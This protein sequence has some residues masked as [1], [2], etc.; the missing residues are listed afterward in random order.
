MKAK[1]NPRDSEKIDSVIRVTTGIIGSD[2]GQALSVDVRDMIS[3][4]DRDLDR[5]S[6]PVLE[7]GN[8]G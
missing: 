3:S 1:P 8:F 4:N 2:I 5:K 7:T 6:L